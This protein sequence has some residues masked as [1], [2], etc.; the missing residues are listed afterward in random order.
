[1]RAERIPERLI[2]RVLIV[3]PILYTAL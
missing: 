3:N 1:M 2:A